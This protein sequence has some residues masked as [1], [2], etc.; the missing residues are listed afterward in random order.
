MKD[1]K[2]YNQFYPKGRNGK[3]CKKTGCERHE[4]Y[5]KWNC[6]SNA[7]RFCTECKHAGVSQY[8]AK[9]AGK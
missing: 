9:G 5:L 2:Y 7:L 8:K 4:E 6:G 3:E 1:Q